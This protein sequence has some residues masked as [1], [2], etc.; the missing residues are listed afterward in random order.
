MR[1][2][3]SMNPP[4]APSEP[5]LLP[6]Q[7]LLRRIRTG[8]RIAH[9]V[10]AAPGGYGKSTLLR[11]LVAHEPGSYYLAL[12]PADA[13]LAIFQQRLAALPAQAAVIV[14]DDVHHLIGADDALTWLATRLRAALPRWVLG[15]R[16]IP[17]ALTATAHR[18][19]PLLLD[20]TDL[21]FRPSESR[22]LLRNLD[23][24]RA[25]FWHERAQGWPQALA[26]LA[27]GGAPTATPTATAT[28]AAIFAYLAEAV[29]ATLPA[30]LTAFVQVSALPLQFNDELIADLLAQPIAQVASLRAEVQRHNLFLETAEAPGWFKYHELV[31]DYVCSQVAAARRTDIAARLVD[32]FATAGDL[33]MAVEHAVDGRLYA[34]AAQLMS[35]HGGRMLLDLGWLH[36]YARWLDA[37]PETVL[38]QWPLALAQYGFALVY[39][40]QRG[41]E[42]MEHLGRAQRLADALDTLAAKEVALRRATA[43]HL[44]GQPEQAL[45]L[46]LDVLAYPGFP[47]HSQI[48]GRLYLAT[49][50]ARLNRL[51]DASQAHQET[52]LLLAT[53]ADG[54]ERRF[55]QNV[56]RHNRGSGIEAV[57]GDFGRFAQTLHLSLA[58]DAGKP[59]ALEM[60]YLGCCILHENL[61]DWA[62]LADDLTQIKRARLQQMGAADAAAYAMT[63]K[64]EIF[65]WAALH[66]G[67]RDFGA[68]QPLIESFMA[69]VSD[70]EAVACGQWLQAWSL[71]A[72]ARYADCVA[73]VDAL[74]SH[75]DEPARFYRA[76]SAFERAAA[77][78]C[79]DRPDWDAGIVPHLRFHMQIGAK[80]YLLRWRLLLALACS[81]SADREESGGGAAVWRK[82]VRFVHAALRRDG[83]DRLLIQREPDLAGRFWVLCQAEAS[84]PAHALAALQ[85]LRQFTPIANLLTSLSPADSTRQRRLIAAMAAMGREEAIPLLEKLAQ[86]TRDA[87]IVAAVEQALG[88]LEALPPPS[89]AVKL[90]GGFALRRGGAVVSGA[91]WQ[92]PGVRKLF[93]YFCLHH[94]TR[95]SRTQ[96]LHDLWPD[97]D[98]QR[99]L[100]AFRTNFSRLGN[101]LEPYLRRRT[102]MRY[103]VV[104]GDNYIFDPQ[105]TLVQIDAAEFTHAVQAALELRSP[106]DAAQL[107]GL[108]AALA[109]WDAPLIEAAYALWAVHAGEALTERFAAGAVLASEQLLAQDR[110]TEAAYWAERGVTVAPWCEACWQTLMRVAARQGQRSLALKHYERAVAALTRELDAPPAPATAALAVRLRRNEEI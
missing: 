74:P 25:A 55:F 1:E 72:Q 98:P 7:R 97:S 60:D 54:E 83:Y 43:H 16:I 21:A 15:G 101:V 59:A 23:G 12:T 36:S 10:I 70:A 37:I 20:S 32:Y 77:A 39:Q 44:L 61:G 84:A 45:P 11:S 71:R 103:F 68:A 90:L 93:I 95:L 13:D 34:A 51:R 26:L 92:R 56:L 3:A 63:A 40:R 58:A 91:A 17:E 27:R 88:R 94:G 52:A 73:W 65:Y 109:L 35:E 57:R 8:L 110:L 9:V 5:P 86:T 76:A 41:A 48:R 99:A 69:A 22:T 2:E 24:A 67:R 78:H 29:F 96:I 107:D 75:Y 6:R 33:R 14:L 31:R 42:G 108:L 46:L 38:A 66:V 28:H 30:S 49:V 79:A 87:A 80:H 19:A 47:L 82:H 85:E 100:T 106:L 50:L 104:N 62:A 53:L 81:A 64:W 105:R 89:L 102:P 4:A 18:A